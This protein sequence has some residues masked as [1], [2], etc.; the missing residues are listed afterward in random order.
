MMTRDEIEADRRERLEKLD[1][2]NPDPGWR[3]H[4]APGSF[5]CHEA[6]HT[7]SILQ[8]VVEENLVDHPAVLLDP[9]W[10]ALASRATEALADLYQAIGGRHGER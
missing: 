3:A 7:A 1:R 2:D 6:L 9:E 10:F 8:A 5:G 4:F